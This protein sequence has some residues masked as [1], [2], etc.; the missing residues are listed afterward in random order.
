MSKSKNMDAG[1]SR[2]KRTLRAILNAIPL[3]EVQEMVPGRLDLPRLA[4]IEAMVRKNSFFCET[5][6]KSWYNQLSLPLSAL[7]YFAIR[8]C[9]RT[10]AW[11][12]LPMGWK[13]SVKITHAGTSVLHHLPN[14]ESAS[15]MF[16][17]NGYRFSYSQQDLHADL[18]GVLEKEFERLE[19]SN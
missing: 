13:S 1:V 19:Q 11:A 18:K 15:L 5:D 12:T 16:I 7:P 9:G 4:D 6:G 10:Y 8:V 2:P 3:N 14:S 17:D